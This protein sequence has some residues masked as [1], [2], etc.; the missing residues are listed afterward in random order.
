MASEILRQLIHHHCTYVVRVIVAD[1]SV[2]LG[3]LSLTLQDQDVGC[4]L[5]CSNLSGCAAHRRDEIILLS[6]SSWSAI[7][8]KQRSVSLSVGTSL[9]SCTLLELSAGLIQIFLLNSMSEY[10]RVGIKVKSLPFSD[11]P[12]I[13]SNESFMLWHLR[14]F[15]A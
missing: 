7:S 10:L 2:H 14:A 8:Y 15:L 11:T 6:F 13:H 12:P 3:E 9:S 1:M 5:I 4:A